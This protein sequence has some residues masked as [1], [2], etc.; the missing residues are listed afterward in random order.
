MKTGR[1]RPLPFEL[2]SKSRKFQLGA[3]QKIKNIRGD[4]PILL[5]WT[6]FFAKNLD[7]RD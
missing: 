2:K 5:V 4:Q 1:M 6:A 3:S 7:N